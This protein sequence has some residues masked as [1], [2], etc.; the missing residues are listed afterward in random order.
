MLIDSNI[1][2]GTEIGCWWTPWGYV[3]DAYASNYGLTTWTAGLGAGLRWEPGR[4]GNFFI[5][6][7]YEYGWTGSDF[8]E[9]N[10]IFKLEF[11]L[12]L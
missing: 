5:N 10:H 9:D 12:L 8:L 7:G 2:A 11:G 1:Q 6:G 4:D 3:C